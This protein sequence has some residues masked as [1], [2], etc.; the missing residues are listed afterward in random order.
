V[1]FF[2]GRNIL[3]KGFSFADY[4]SSGASVKVQSGVA[5]V[6]RAW[7]TVEDSPPAYWNTVGRKTTNG[8]ALTDAGLAAEGYICKSTNWP[9]PDPNPNV[10]AASTDEMISDG[11][12]GYDRRT[13]AIGN[14]LKFSKKYGPSGQEDPTRNP[15]GTDGGT[16]A[17]NIIT[18]PFPRN[19]PNVEALLQRARSGGVNAYVDAATAPNFDDIYNS[20]DPRV[21]FVDA[22]GGDVRLSMSDKNRKPKGIIVV[23]CGNLTIQGEEFTGIVLVLNDEENMSRQCGAGDGKS[24]YKAESADVKGYVYAESTSKDDALYVD[25]GSTVSPLPTEQG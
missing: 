7:N 10:V 3:L 16:P 21:V 24:K 11:I 5:D 19:R 4:G 20:D 15:N 6:L 2:S 22:N 13:G 12:Y 14:K 17:S 1:S 23:R 9:A 18:Y 8:G 25:S